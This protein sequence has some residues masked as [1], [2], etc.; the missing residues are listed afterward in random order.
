MYFRIAIC[1]AALLS[2]TGCDVIK[3]GI[4]STAQ[5]VNEAFPISVD[6][7][8]AHARLSKSLE[9]DAGAAKSTEAQ[10]NQLL[11]ARAFSCSALADIGRFDTAKTVRAKIT[12]R[13]CFTKQDIAL[14]NWIGSRRLATLIKAPPIV[15]V[16]AIPPKS[17]ITTTEQTSQ[18]ALA[19]AANVLVYGGGGKFVAVQVP[20]GK[21]ISEMTVP[22]SQFRT[23]S[24]SP[25]GRIAAIPGND[26]VRF[27]DVQT[28]EPLWAATK[29]T[30][31]LT[32]LPEVDAVV[33]S[34]S[35]NNEPALLDI[36]QGKI[37]PYT[38]PDKRPTWAVTMPQGQRIVGSYMTASLVKHARSA[39]GGIEVSP[40]R[41]W[42]FG[43]APVNNGT[44]LLMASGKKLAYMS[45]QNISVFDLE[46]S[47]AT[48][49][50]GNTLGIRAIAKASESFVIF[51]GYTPGTLGPESTNRLF[52]VDKQELLSARGEKLSEGGLLPV[53]QRTAFIKRSNGGLTIGTSVEGENPQ[54]LDALVAEADLA[55]QLKKLEEAERNE[56]LAG[57][58]AR[59]E[60][61]RP[62]V[63]SPGMSAAESAR[64]RHLAMA[65]ARGEA[66]ASAMKAANAAEM[67]AE[68]ARVMQAATMPAPAISGVPPNAKVAFVGV[69]QSA[70]SPG[71]QQPGNVRINVAP[72]NEPLV[73]VLSNYE[74]VTWMINSGGRPISAVLVSGYEHANVVGA[75]NAQVVRMGRTHAYKL[76]SPEY[77]KLQIEVTRYLGKPIGVFQG[78][79]GGRE[80]TVR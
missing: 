51:D 42:Q 41:Q 43:A 32:W 53:A 74:G 39:N 17:L 19:E 27:L 34:Q 37:E 48:T 77:S 28:G 52:D 66:A 24:L 50:P 18:V 40:V 63:P 54:P 44:P 68:R 79:Y 33:L 4:T 38:V 7:E 76:D 47:Q 80:F 1:A 56:K 46:S 59:I 61:T 15:P 45:G 16:A 11:K 26:V 21:R 78:V 10:F 55:N 69:Y 12:D 30:S 22:E 70:D 36:Q 8:L 49:V 73:L 14:T 35:G 23:I 13:E 62:F 72:G 31:V 5:K 57:A 9:S 25:N 2:L 67:A 64:A 20:D 71:R 75:G 3:A 58:R 6:M 29:Y 60:A 65:E